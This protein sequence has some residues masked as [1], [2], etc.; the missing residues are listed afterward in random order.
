MAW[1][2]TWFGEEYLELYP[3]RDVESARREVAFAL[4]RLDRV[5][6]PCW[7][8]PAARG[9]TRWM[10]R[11]RLTPVGSTTP[12]LLELARA[13]VKSPARARD[14]RSL[15]PGRDVSLGRQLLQSFGTFWRGDNVRV[16]T[17]IERVLSRGGNSSDDTF[18][19]PCP[20]AL[21]PRRAAHRRAGVAN[22]RWGNQETSRVEK[23][24]EVRGGGSTET[25]RESVR[26]T[27]GGA[28]RHAHGSGLEMRPAGG[29]ST[30]P[31]GTRFAALDRARG[32]TVTSAVVPF[33]RYPGLPR[34]YTV[35]RGTAR[36]LS[37]PPDLDSAERRARRLLGRPPA[38]ARVRLPLA[39]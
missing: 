18:A 7:I 14:M 36:A 22:R 25:F 6:H 4:A 37:D 39:R 17:E 1:W 38:S 9:G 34:L 24:I 31:G 32:E 29:T 2:E 5:R 3:H 33:D 23:E 11:E 8:S 16:V 28:R 13:R 30:Q 20:G 21:V 26:A 15:P 10:R 35:P 19:G 27:R 12:P